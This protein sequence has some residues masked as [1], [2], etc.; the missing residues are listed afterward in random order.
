AEVPANLKW[1]LWLGPSPERP[2]ANA[3]HPFKWRGWWDFGTGAIGD[4]GCHSINLPFMALDLRDPDT[5]EAETSGHNKDS[6]PQW[7]IIRSPFR[8]RDRRPALTMTWYDGKKLPP[9]ELFGGEQIVAGGSLIVGEKGTLYAQND[10]AAM[11]KL[12]GNVNE[13]KVETKPS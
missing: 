5:V 3:Y 9:A 2:Y 10:Y 7:S 6:F 11:Y 1:D 12:M 4:M 8:E 13:P